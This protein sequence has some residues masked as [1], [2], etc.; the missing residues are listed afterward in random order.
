MAFFFPSP[1]STSVDY[2]TTYILTI[3]TSTITH[4]YSLLFTKAFNIFNNISIMGRGSYDTTGTQ[5]P[6]PK[7]QPKPKQNAE[8]D[9]MGI[10]GDDC[11]E[12]GVMNWGRGSYDTTGTQKPKPKLQPKPK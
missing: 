3:L 11:C 8:A 2:L 12:S 6:K 9:E 1:S 10:F 4:N 7:P 5:K